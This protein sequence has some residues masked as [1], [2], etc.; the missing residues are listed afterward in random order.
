RP[1][2]ELLAEIDL[3]ASNLSQ[4][5]AVLRRAGIVSSYREGATVMYRLSTPAVGELMGAA[6]WIL[7]SVLTSQEGLRA[8]LQ[9]ELLSAVAAP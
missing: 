2:R 9:A 6:R 3:E 4:Q 8:E 7:A 1:V 5:L